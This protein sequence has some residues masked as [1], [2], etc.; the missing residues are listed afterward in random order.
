M[1]GSL[2]KSGI[3]LVIFNLLW[4]FHLILFPLTIVSIVC[5]LS[6]PKAALH[7][8]QLLTTAIPFLLFST[9]KKWDTPTDDPADAMKSATNTD[10]DERSKNVTVESKTIYFVRHGEST[11]NDTFN[12]GD[13]SLPLFLTTFL[14]NLI[15]AVVYEWYLLL[16]G[17]DS[18]SWFYDSPLSSKGIAQARSLRDF[19]ASAIDGTTNTTETEKEAIRVLLD[20]TNTT[21][22]STKS[23]SRLVSSNLRRA[24]VTMAVA[25]Q[26]RL[27]VQTPDDKIWI[28]TDL[29]EV[30][31]NPDAL[32]ITPA[33]KDVTVSSSF[34]DRA[35]ANSVPSSSSSSS[36]PPIDMERVY[37][38]QV[39]TG[40]YHKGNKPLGESGLQRVTA[41]S[42]TVFS[43]G[44]G[45]GFQDVDTVIC[46]GHSFWFRSFF[47]TYL[48]Y[49]VDH[50]AK[51]KKIVNGGV[52]KF[53][54][55]KVGVEGA[56]EDRFF[57]D[58]ASVQVIYA[59]F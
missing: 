41:F 4:I 54:L 32:C 21:T 52:V 42:R 2:I 25:F 15:R 49:K 43:K 8:L 24:I 1:I 48:P 51:R 53:T 55:T 18:E 46:A 38:K 22:G 44:G 50:I 34:A 30:S 5:L 3:F 59:G 57:I 26:D 11:W 6:N 29:Q 37:R 16:S 47:R 13:R 35:I 45:G 39:E 19:M 23:R 36:T 20:N 14:P 40:Y 33:G 56:G 31:S 17:Q 10:D 28:M 12:R 7:K 9:E 27:D 58:P